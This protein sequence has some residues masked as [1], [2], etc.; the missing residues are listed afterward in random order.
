MSDP[1]NMRQRTRPRGFSLVELI[2]A[3]VI[4]STGAALTLQGFITP[5]QSIEYD[6]EVQTATHNAQACAEHLL[7]RRSIQTMGWSNIGVGASTL[8]DSVTLTAGYQRNITINTI[9]TD[10]PCL[11][12][13]TPVNPCREVTITVV[14]ASN[15][16]VAAT[17]FRF[18]IVNY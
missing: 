12:A 9:A 2:I 10:P 7:N 17:T 1:R 13:F 8:C 3:I 4:V 11:A 15:P 5:A 14:K 6:I 18:T 16:K